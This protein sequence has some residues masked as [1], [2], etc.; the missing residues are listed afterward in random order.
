MSLTVQTLF[1]TFDESELKAI[2]SCLKEMSECM[3][4]IDDEKELMKDIVDTTHD[5]FKIPKKYTPANMYFWRGFALPIEK[6]RKLGPF[7]DRES[8]KGNEYFS[9]YS[10]YFVSFSA[11][12]TSVQNRTIYKHT[13]HVHVTIIFRTTFIL[14]RTNVLSMLDVES[15][16]LVSSIQ[17]YQAFHCIASC[18]LIQLHEI[19]AK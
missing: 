9:K 10:E 6:I 19:C 12:Y 3:S 2:K 15:I 11:G 5:K 8:L 4:K 1:G 16:L 17:I 7:T 18:H 14:F 13:T